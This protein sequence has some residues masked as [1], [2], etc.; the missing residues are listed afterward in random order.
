MSKLPTGY[1]RWKPAPVRGN[2]LFPPYCLPSCPRQSSKYRTCRKGHCFPH[3]Q[4][5]C[6]LSWPAFVKLYVSLLLYFSSS[7]V[8]KH[9][10][11]SPLS[12]LSLTYKHDMS[13]MCSVEVRMSWSRNVAD[14]VVAHTRFGRVRARVCLRCTCVPACACLRVCVCVGCVYVRTI[15][16][17]LRVLWIIRLLI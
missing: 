12:S 3:Q 5:I 1:N 17:G 9:V 15:L 4:P 13:L 2:L 7:E 8:F 16:P 11:W 6:N 10:F 14:I